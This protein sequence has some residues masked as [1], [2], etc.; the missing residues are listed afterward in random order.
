MRAAKS[1]FSSSFRLSLVTG[2]MAVALL[3]APIAARADAIPGK[4][5][6]DFTGVDTAGKPISLAAL[7]GKIVVLEWTNHECPYTVKHYV[8]QNMQ[9][10]Q[11]DLAAQ[12][13][14]WLT[15]ASS[16]KGEQGHVTAK[17]AEKLTADR[18]AAPAHVV[19]DHDGKIGRL[20]GA[21]TTPHMYVIGADGMLAYAGAIDDKPSASQ[22]DVKGARNYVRE[23]VA[24][25]A[26][27]KPVATPTT[28][29]YGCSVKY[30]PLRS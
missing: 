12:G 14:V 8:T 1:Y 21:R 18:K 6:P 29:A 4:P 13:V 17:D 3:A 11:R 28:R 15:I 9:G 7:K 2:G 25:V 27:G 16:A 19:L 5:A 20:Y 26:A 10:L 22:A 30:A 23:A 24:A